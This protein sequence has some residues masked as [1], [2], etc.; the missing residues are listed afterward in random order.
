MDRVLS[1][2]RVDHLLRAAIA[3]L[4]IT[5]TA[6]LGI[7]DGSPALTAATMALVGL[8]AWVTDERRWFQLSQPLANF[9]AL[10]I[11]TVAVVNAYNSDRQGQL[12]VVAHLQSYLQYVL[13]FQ[14]KSARVYWQLALLSL[15]QVAIASTL[16]P[17]PV[18]GVMLL[19]YVFA[20][21]VAFSLLVLHV[22]SQRWN[23]PHDE[24]ASHGT[25]AVEPH[26]AA[27]RAGAG[28]DRGGGQPVLTGSTSEASAREL[29]GGVLRLAALVSLFAVLISAAI[30][31]ATPR[32]QITN[33]EAATIEP[34]RSVGFSKTVTLGEFGEVVNNSDLVMRVSFFRGQSS[35][36][37]K[38]TG[39]PLFRGT[40]V[41]QYQ[42]GRWTQGN[43]RNFVVLPLGASSEFVRQRILV[44]PLDVSELFCVFPVFALQGDPRLRIDAGYELL[45][46]QENLRGDSIEFEIGTTGIVNG[47]QRDLLPCYERVSRRRLTQM[48]E[49]TGDGKDP[50]E[51]LRAIAARVLQEQRIDPADRAAAA[52]ALNQYLSSSGDYAY[53]LESQLRAPG[54]DPLEDFATTHRNGHCEYFAGALVMMLRSQNIPARMAIG[55]KGGEWN[56]VGRYYQVQQL[57]AHTWVEVFLE[58]NE[59]PP[60]SFEEEDVPPGAWLVLDP[61]EGT[62]QASGTQNAIT[63]V[64]RVRQYLDYMQVL[65]VNYVV[66]LNS[67]RQQQNIFEPLA[68]GASA[69]VDRVVSPQAWEERWEA[70]GDSPWGTFWQWYRR[71]WFSWRGGLVAAL[72]SGGLV[73][74]YAGSRRLLCVLRRWGLVGPG[75]AGDEPPMLEMCRRL[76][77]A[78]ARQ[79]L[80]RQ[81]AQ[82]A[83]EFAVLAGGELAER[84]EHRGVAHLPRRVV[85]VFHR[86]RFGGRTLDNSELQAVEHALVELERTLGRSRG[87]AQVGP[88]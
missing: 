46:R 34:L 48:P 7:G 58:R 60:D 31:F 18:F 71:H 64:A 49:P 30:F 5:A 1:E 36:A 61:T 63:A 41:S 65:W 72:F 50:L 32:W 40:V 56:E 14:R 15:G 77:A 16:I 88:V 26:G 23:V 3:A 38:L 43:R 47:R 37:F 39:E 66:G 28:I 35:Q 53:N 62:R 76:E 25:S 52:R 80:T 87:K 79:G 59:I 33:R 82:T 11:M 13:L 85:E 9:A 70:L 20:G 67:K 83:F 4:L 54:V 21:V 42:D 69:T 57:H 51:G 6:L 2:L 86:V 75:R 81:P 10:S 27:L 68:Q 73:F 44:Q 24:Q 45:A 84:L 78:L 19:A 12:L 74:L 55:F 8:T 17:G 29:L 22:D